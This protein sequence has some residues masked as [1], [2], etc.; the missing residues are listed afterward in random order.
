L[1]AERAA[2]IIGRLQ[3]VAGELVAADLV[4]TS[5]SGMDPHISVEAAKLQATSVANARN[6]SFDEVIRLIED[7]AYQPSLAGFGVEPLVNVL[8]INLVLDHLNK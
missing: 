6:L 3:P 2:E 1:I 5:G 8:E 4:S 7:K